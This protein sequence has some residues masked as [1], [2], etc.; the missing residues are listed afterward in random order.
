IMGFTGQST[1]FSLFSAGAIIKMR[2]EKLQ[3]RHFTSQEGRR[4]DDGLM[5][6]D[7][8]PVVVA[9]AWADG[10]KRYEG[11]NEFYERNY[12]YASES[13]GAKPELK[14][15]TVE[16]EYTLPKGT[17]FSLPVEVKGEVGD[18]QYYAHPI[19]ASAQPQLFTTGATRTGRVDFQERYSWAGGLEPGSEMDAKPG[20]YRVVCVASSGD[21]EKGVAPQ[22]AVRDAVVNITDGTPFV[23][24][25]GSA[26][27]GRVFS[28][29]EI[30]GLE[31]ELT[32][33]VDPMFNGTK[34][35][36]VMS[37]DFGQ[38]WKYTLVDEA[39][40]SGRCKVVL[41]YVEVGVYEGKHEQAVRPCIIRVEVIGRIAYAQS[42]YHPLA[43][44]T[45]GEA[46]GGFTLS[47]KGEGG[48]N[49]QHSVRFEKVPEERELHLRKDE[50][51]PSA[52]QDVR[53]KNLF[54][55]PLNVEYKQHATVALSDGRQLTLRTWTAENN[56][57][58]IVYEQRIY[59][60]PTGGEP[61]FALR[62]RVYGE[63]DVSIAQKGGGPIAD[64]MHIAQGS[65]ISVKASP[66]TGYRLKFLLVGGKEFTSGETLKVVHDVMVEAVF[67][68]ETV[69]VD[70]EVVGRGGAV[71]LE[72]AHNPRAVPAGKNVRVATQH[73][74]GWALRELTLNGADIMADDKRSFTAAAGKKIRAVFEELK[75]PI[76]QTVHG[77]GRILYALEKDAPE[78][79]WVELTEYP[80]GRIIFAKGLPAAGWE[81]SALSHNGSGIMGLY[82]QVTV[83][84]TN[85]VEAT[86]V[87]KT[88][89]GG[90]T[91]GGTG[92]Q[93]GGGSTGGPAGGSAGGSGGSSNGGG[94]VPP[95][96]GNTHSEST[97]GEKQQEVAPSTVERK[98]PTPVEAAGAGLRLVPNPAV[99]SFR[100]EGLEDGSAVEV[101]NLLGVRVLS[102]M[103]TE[104]I[105]TGNLARGVYVVHAGGRTF[106][107]VLR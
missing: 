83:G 48:T 51:P 73:I 94:G 62:K 100:M 54:G 107:L 40:N 103:Q 71:V 24:S 92:P 3:G 30:P 63:G 37:D 101:Y 28:T 16:K 53:A 11:E 10:R 57:K 78:S 74:E 84:K 86:F 69:P 81:L 26:V 85:S 68:R 50:Q 58:T 60:Y 80:L 88:N 61:G 21:S 95:S 32:W 96:N 45:G 87:K 42:T 13:L 33:D 19:D 55:N 56:G 6:G 31:K 90:S 5:D 41:P 65:E 43:S 52:P 46:A 97:G 23:L 44:K 29:S 75:Y 82:G 91:G 49:A 102:T 15:G 7:G 104:R 35:R 59:H 25:G 72:W 38:T 99:D 4:K 89:S 67:E 8:H 20:K 36:I 2:N 105:Y 79:E 22:M 76:R 39:P 93:A 106:R 9:G 17:L 66:K 34:V 14:D 18:F 98:S 12:V 77:E 27:T 70:I 64:L 47:F 1:F